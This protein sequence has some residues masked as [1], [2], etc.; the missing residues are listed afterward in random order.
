[1]DWPRINQFPEWFVNDPVKRY[2]IADISSMTQ[3]GI[4][5]EELISGY[6]I[7]LNGNKQ[8]IIIHSPA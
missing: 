5:G 2:L 7:S 8:F 4:T 3:K 1:M 6:E